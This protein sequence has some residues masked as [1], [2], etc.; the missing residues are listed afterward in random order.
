MISMTCSSSAANIVALA[1][2]TE[3]DRWTA[4][5][6]SEIEFGSAF[7]KAPC[8]DPSILFLALRVRLDFVMVSEHWASRPEITGAEKTKLVVAV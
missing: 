3:F 5:V 8:E 1:T 2:L 6:D 7:I 4:I